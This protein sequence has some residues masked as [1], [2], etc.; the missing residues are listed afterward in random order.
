M[1]VVSRNA[2]LLVLSNFFYVLCLFHW[3]GLALVFVTSAIVFVSMGDP[4]DSHVARIQ[5]DVV[6]SKL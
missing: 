2:S 4:F 3:F 5:S 1:R 6:S